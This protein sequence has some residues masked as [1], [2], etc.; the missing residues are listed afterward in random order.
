MVPLTPFLLFWYSH[1]EVVIIDTHSHMNF[2]V[3][4]GLWILLLTSLKNEIPW[5]TEAE[6]Y[7]DCYYRFVCE[8]LRVGVMVK[9]VNIPVWQEN[10]R[11]IEVLVWG[12][13]K[14]LMTEIKVKHGEE[15]NLVSLVGTIRMCLSVT[16]SQFPGR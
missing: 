8:I 3:S 1:L 7:T 11:R 4:P 14:L 2:G 15:E 9:Y 5:T 13:H 16:S 6:L 10:V 12:L